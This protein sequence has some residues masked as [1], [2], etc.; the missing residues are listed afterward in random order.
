MMQNMAQEFSKQ[1]VSS[2]ETTIT[3]AFQKMNESL[4]VMLSTISKSQ[5]EV[6]DELVGQFLKQLRES[7]HIEF[8]GFNAAVEEMA[9]SQKRNVLYTEKLF[10]QLSVELNNSF[11]KEDHSMRQIVK[12]MTDIQKQYTQAMEETMQKNQEL[13]EAQNESCRHT[14]SYMQ[15]A[16]EKSAKFW[17]AC[18]QTM[19]KY[20]DSASK[21]FG[22]I[23]EIGK[24]NVNLLKGY[25]DS[26]KDLM[27]S[28]EA[29]KEE[30]IDREGKVYTAFEELYK[31]NEK[32]ILNYNQRVGEFVDA[33]NM[34]FTVLR[35]M[36][37]LLNQ[38]EVS[39][40]ANRVQLGRET[41]A[42]KEQTPEFDPQ[43]IKHLEQ[44]LE[45]EGERQSELIEELNSI[46]REFVKAIQKNGKFSLFR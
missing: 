23:Q 14:V 8:A 31:A 10:Q 29:L 2:F 42:A 35:N 13:V 4:D 17:V 26:Q 43:M 7:F 9:S 3:P 36:E 44:V 28:L 32:L 30:F 15:E 45:E 11:L 19:Q 16:E 24:T 33:Q 34:I 1:L 41:A 37:D 39:G 20:L 27:A 38:I 25:E 22:D 21:A 40:A 18:N 5:K 46:M 12:E 6:L